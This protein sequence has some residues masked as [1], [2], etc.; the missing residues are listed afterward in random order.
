[1]YDIML[2]GQPVGKAQLTREGGLWCIRCKCRLSGEV[3]YQVRMVCGDE[4]RCLG[5]LVPESGSFVLTARIPAKLIG[6]QQPCF[7]AEPRR[8]QL[9]GKF[10]PICAEEPFAYLSRLEHAFMEVRSGKQ[11]IILTD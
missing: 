3:P 2:G 1:M 10:V 9:Q 8:P 7:V 11:G 4:Q 5:L 6:D